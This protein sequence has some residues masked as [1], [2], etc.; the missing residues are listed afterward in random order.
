MAGR[1]E[2]PKVMVDG[3][4]AQL[5]GGY[6]LDN[7]GTATINLGKVEDISKVAVTY[8]EKNLLPN[9][10]GSIPKTE[11]ISKNW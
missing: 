5:S 3:N 8:K 9:I 7:K 10:N 2:D 1:H 6:Y 4:K 11:K